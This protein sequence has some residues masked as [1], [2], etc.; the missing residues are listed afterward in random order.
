MST[1]LYPYD[2]KWLVRFHKDE[3]LEAW[4]FELKDPQSWCKTIADPLLFNT[5]EINR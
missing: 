4:N 2:G 5:D 3:V 1:N